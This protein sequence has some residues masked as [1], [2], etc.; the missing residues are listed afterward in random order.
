MNYFSQDNYETPHPSQP[1]SSNVF[2]HYAKTLGIFSIF[3][4]FFN[5]F[6]G[7]FVCG[8]L[9]IVLAVLS[10]GY[11]TKMEKNA[12]VGLTTGIISMIL[13][14]AVLAFSIYS[15]LYVPEIREHF[16][17]LYEQIYGEPIDDSINEIFDGFVLPDTI[18][19]EENFEFV[20]KS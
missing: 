16:N 7:V 18:K 17:S 1:L 19:T 11:H 6:I 15:I 5:M 13:Q 14:L 4:A 8:G 12:V 3:C 2:A 10:K 20:L 9:A